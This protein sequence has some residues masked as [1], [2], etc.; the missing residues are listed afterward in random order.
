MSLMLLLI[1]S[2]W[3]RQPAPPIKH[4]ASFIVNKWPKECGKSK[5]EIGHPAEIEGSVLALPIDYMPLK[6]MHKHL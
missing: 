3:F 2:L 1:I 4:T 5:A 6:C